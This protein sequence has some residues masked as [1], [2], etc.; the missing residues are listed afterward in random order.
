MISTDPKKTCSKHKAPC[1]PSALHDEAA[2][3]S[4]LGVMPSFL[5]ESYPFI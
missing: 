1:A 2:P 3:V 4:Q 5:S